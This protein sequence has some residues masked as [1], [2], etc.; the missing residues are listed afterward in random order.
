MDF[1]LNF[2]SFFWKL[3]APNHFLLFFIFFSYCFYSTN[4][5]FGLS[6]FILH[7]FLFPF[8]FLSFYAIFVHMISFFF[9]KNSKIF[10]KNYKNMCKI[11][12]LL[13]KESFLFHSY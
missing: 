2:F 10:R 8:R 9:F 4:F 11:M 7:L 1:P 5:L 6:Y 3:E 13:K 12:I